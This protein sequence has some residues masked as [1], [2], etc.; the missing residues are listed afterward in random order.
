MQIWQLDLVQVR[1][2]AEACLCLSAVVETAPLLTCRFGL[3]IVWE[4][5][6][7]KPTVLSQNADLAVGSGDIALESG[8]MQGLAAALQSALQL[9]SG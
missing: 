8:P 1:S 3:D 7:V 2:H 4:Y 6:A 5:P 9:S